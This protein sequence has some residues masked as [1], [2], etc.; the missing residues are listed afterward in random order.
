MGI[1]RAREVGL[2]STTDINALLYDGDTPPNTCSI[3]VG[4][5]DGDTKL[6]QGGLSGL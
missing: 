2:S 3:R 4:H 5:F 6:A 1:H